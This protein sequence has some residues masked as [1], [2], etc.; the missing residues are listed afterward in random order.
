MLTTE[1]QFGKIM[2]K[3]WSNRRRNIIASNL[4]Y[5]THPWCNKLFLIDEQ[6]WDIEGNPQMCCMME[7]KERKPAKCKL[8]LKNWKDCT[9]A[10]CKI[11]G[12]SLTWKQL[13]R[14][15]YS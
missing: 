7:C 5:F 2:P 10:A 12:L 14:Y 8:A 1:I 9:K 13:S 3:A 4:A 15:K 6:F 11:F